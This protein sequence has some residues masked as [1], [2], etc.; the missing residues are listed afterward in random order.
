MVEF[1]KELRGDDFYYEIGK[2]YP[3]IDDMVGHGLEN[4]VFVRQP[5]SPKNKNWWTDFDKTDN[6]IIFRILNQS[7]LSLVEQIEEDRLL[8]L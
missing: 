8:Q 3:S 5:N 2:R 1:L 7:E 4:K 6:G